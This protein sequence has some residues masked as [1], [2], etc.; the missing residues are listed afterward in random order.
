M[1]EHYKMVYSV[2]ALQDLEEI[3]LYISTQLLVPEI[4]VNQVNRIRKAIRA[5]DSMP[6]RFAL[7]EW[8]PWHSMEVHKLPVDHYVVFYIVDV[9]TAT[10]SIVRIFYGGRNIQEIVQPTREK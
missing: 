9:N 7:V 3:Y 8:E 5:L 1:M 10:V 2:D 4:A 6:M